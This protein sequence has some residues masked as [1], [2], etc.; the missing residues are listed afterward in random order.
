MPSVELKTLG[1]EKE[2]SGSHASLLGFG[3]KNGTLLR[4]LTFTITIVYKNTEK[5][6]RSNMELTHFPWRHWHVYN[7]Y[8][9]ILYFVFIII[10]RIKPIYHGS[11]IVIQFHWI[12]TLWLKLKKW[13]AA[14]TSSPGLS[15]SGS[16]TTRSAPIK[17]WKLSWAD[18]DF[19]PA[20]WK[21]DNN[22]LVS[23]QPPGICSIARHVG[24][25][26]TLCSFAHH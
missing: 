24:E 10:Y 3:L 8:I 20:I 22:Y 2:P 13:W 21:C 15:P 16:S 14:I 7:I 5:P 25:M 23:A 4:N 17:R 9:Y 6:W 11:F 12:S 1:V 19:L 18:N 26:S